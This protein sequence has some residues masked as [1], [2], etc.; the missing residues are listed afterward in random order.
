MECYGMAWTGMGWHGVAWNAMECHGMAWNAMEWHGMPWN[1]MECHGMPWNAMECYGMLWNAMECYGMEW[2][3]MAGN[4][5]EWHG[6]VWK[7]MEWHAHDCRRVHAHLRIYK[8]TAH[9]HQ[10]T[11]YTHTLACTPT[12]ITPSDMH[13]TQYVSLPYRKS[14]RCALPLVGCRKRC[15]TLNLLITEARIGRSAPRAE[16][17]AKQ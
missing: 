9:K 4:D 12:N 1:A 15:K 3:G 7:G 14:F 6:M 16:V 10:R 11:C 13:I 8:H 2:H 5:M 17:V